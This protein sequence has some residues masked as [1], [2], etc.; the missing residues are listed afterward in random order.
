MPL[1]KALVQQKTSE[2][3]LIKQYQLTGRNQ[4]IKSIKHEVKSWFTNNQP[5]CM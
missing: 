2:S 5:D 4:L 3:E 1:L